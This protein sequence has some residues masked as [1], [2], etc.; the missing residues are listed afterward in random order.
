MSD[1]DEDSDSEAPEYPES[2]EDE[3]IME[4]PSPLAVFL[5]RIICCIM[6]VPVDNSTSFYCCTYAG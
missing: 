3:D 6:C 1:Q 4:D 2:D 5:F